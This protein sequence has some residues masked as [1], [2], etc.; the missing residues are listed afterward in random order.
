MGVKTFLDLHPPPHRPKQRYSFKEI[1]YTMYL[2]YNYMGNTMNTSINFKIDNQLKKD[3]VRILKEMGLDMTTAFN[4]FTKAVVR[5]RRIPFELKAD[6]AT[7]LD[8]TNKKEL[9]SILKS[10][11]EELRQDPNLALNQKDFLDELSARGI[12]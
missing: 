4:I 11:L 9:E 1:L 8:T 3:F 6:S 2:Q 7:F 5:E 10:R 12:E